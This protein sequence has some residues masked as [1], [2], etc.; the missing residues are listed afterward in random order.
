MKT[1]QHIRSLAIALTA[2]TGLPALA[3][4]PAEPLATVSY[5]DLNLASPAG[6]E[7]LY[8][9]IER[10]AVKVCQLPQGTR[11]LKLEAELAACRQGA[12]DRAI[13]QANLPKLNALHLAKTGRNVGPG[14]YAGRR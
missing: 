4:E 9:R 11:Q 7:A 2:L 1:I 12:T 8:R 13:A 10:A 6:I 14:A 3:A 5:A